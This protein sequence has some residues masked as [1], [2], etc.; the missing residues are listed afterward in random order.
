M[1]KQI[2]II[3]QCGHSIYANKFTKKIAHTLT[4]KI[5]V[6]NITARDM[7]IILFVKGGIVK[8]FLLVLL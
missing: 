2:I 8:D 7:S 3:D 6:K 1:C 4:I 5:K